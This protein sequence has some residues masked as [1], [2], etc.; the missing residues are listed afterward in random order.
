MHWVFKYRI[1]YRNNGLPV[2]DGGF[3][4]TCIISEEKSCRSLPQP[5]VRRPNAIFVRDG[6]GCPVNFILVRVS[7]GGNAENNDEDTPETHA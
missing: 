7:P 5:G 6:G 2:R 1:S 3:L 4:V